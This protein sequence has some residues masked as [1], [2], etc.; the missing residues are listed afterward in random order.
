M[1]PWR[2]EN[3]SSLKNLKALTLI[4]FLVVGVIL[5]AATAGDAN[6]QVEVDDRL[7]TGG[8]VNY[9][10]S[11]R[12]RFSGEYQLRTSFSPFERKQSLYEFGLRRRFWKRLY[13]SA[14]YRFTRTPDVNKNR[15]RASVDVAYRWRKKGF[16]LRISNRVRFQYENELN[17]I[18]R[19]LTLRNKLGVGYNLSKLVDPTFT[20]EVFLENLEYSDV[21]YRFGLDWK[22]D[23][24]LTLTT[25][26]A[27][28]RQTDKKSNNITH[29]FGAMATYRLKRKKRKKNN[30]AG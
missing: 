10:L 20:W 14:S 29:I 15:N 12:L 6:G 2:R 4:K 18:Q 26:Y 3:V 17:T 30:D 5:F 24:R 25:F 8:K 13:L 11:K 7:W 27:Y 21:R 22:L 1:T 28:E 19:E 16:P 9:P 23:K